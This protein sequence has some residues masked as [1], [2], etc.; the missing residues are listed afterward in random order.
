MVQ[1]PRD[2]KGSA[3]DLVVIGGSVG[4][5]DALHTILSALPPDFAGAI[6]IVQH[7][8]A[9]RAA[10]LAELLRAWTA[11]DV[12][13]AEDGD[14]LVEGRVFIAPADRHMFITRE[15]SIALHAGQPIHHVLSSAEPLFES[16][17]IAFGARLTAVVITGGDSD[18]SI[19]VRVVKE[20]GGTV[21]AQ[22]PA[23]AANP[24]M[25]LAAI[26][27]GAV[28]RV[29]PLDAIAGALVERVARTAESE[30]GRRMAAP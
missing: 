21:I 3:D 17:A 28:D 13:D 15:R 30:A 16:A 4:G 20:H 14:L 2:S 22:D 19:G 10:L 6:A 8:M 23:T 11:L 25:P 1:Q 29:L 27:T 26:S 5:I 12:R 24:S 18:G 7:R 9:A